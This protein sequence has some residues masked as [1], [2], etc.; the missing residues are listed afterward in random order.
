VTDKPVGEVL[1]TIRRQKNMNQKVLAQ[2]SGV[3]PGTIGKIEKGTTRSARRTLCRLAD[4]LDRFGIEGAWDLT[5][6]DRR[7][8]G[9]SFTKEEILDRVEGYKQSRG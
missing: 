2:I 7:V 9:T 3:S 4:A 8:P 6:G 1:K 5:G